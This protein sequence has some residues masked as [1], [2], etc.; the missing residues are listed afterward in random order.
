MPSAGG[1]YGRLAGRQK[2]RLADK[3]QMDFETFKILYRLN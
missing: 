2:G 1:S 3:T